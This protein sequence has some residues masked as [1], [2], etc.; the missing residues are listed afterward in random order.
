MKE[1]AAKI[2]TAVREKSPLIQ[3]ITNYVTIGD[4]ANIL[5]AFGASPAMCEAV[6][7]AYEFAKISGAVYFNLGTLT[8][9]HEVAMI[10][11]GLGAKEAGRPVVVDPAGC[12]A[13]PRKR[14]V[15]EHLV[16]TGRV[17]VIKGNMGE[18]MTLAGMDAQ[19]KGVDS[20]GEAAGIEEALTLLAKKYGC[21]AAATGRVDV[22]ADGRQVVHIHNGVE[23]LTGITGAGC[24]LGALCAATAAVCDDMLAATAAAVAAMGIA[25]EIAYEKA[26]LPGSFRTAL[27][28]SV[29][30]LDGAA[31]LERGRFTC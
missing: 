27:F 23:L 6:D 25:G 3:A 26:Q 12:G 14:L 31:I 24:M 9:E 10:E 5:L 15:L 20:V 13:I 17:D 22:V 29:Y 8:K 7:E 28:D 1:K 21:V 30:L 18:M 2:L 19:V 11:A 16:R 4:C